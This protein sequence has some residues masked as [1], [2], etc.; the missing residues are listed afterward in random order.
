MADYLVRLLLTKDLSRWAT[1]ID[2]DSGAARSLYATPE[3]VSQSLGQP[4][5]L[6]Q[7]APALEAPPA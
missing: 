5:D 7:T 2:M 6:F 4:L 1:Y 3:Q